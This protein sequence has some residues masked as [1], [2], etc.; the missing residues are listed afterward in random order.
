MLETS[1]LS[2]QTI[3]TENHVRRRWTD[4]CV[5]E[6]SDA[7]YSAWEIHLS[8]G[9]NRLSRWPA[10][11]CQ[12][13]FQAPGFPGFL[14]LNPFWSVVFVKPQVV[15]FPGM[16]L[17]CSQSDFA[18]ICYYHIGFFAVVNPKTIHFHFLHVFTNCTVISNVPTLGLPFKYETGFNKCKLECS[19]ET[20][21]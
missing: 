1:A 15:F 3:C 11:H 17:G 19:L 5:F 2:I 4:G 8:L 21:A 18:H 7:M 13:S 20:V 6:K 16:E 12:G 10:F 14:S 9:L